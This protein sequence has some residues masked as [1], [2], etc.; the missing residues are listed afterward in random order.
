MNI[1]LLY[2]LWGEL[3]G[4]FSSDKIYSLWRF[5]LCFFSTDYFIRFRFEWIEKLKNISPVD[6][7]T[8]EMFYFIGVFIMIRIIIYGFLE[9]PLRLIFHGKVKKNILSF[10]E[11]M[12][13]TSKWDQSREAIKIVYI[14]APL[15]HKVLFKYGFI[16]SNDLD[17]LILID[18]DSK[19]K[20][21]NDM[22]KM[23]YRWILT[24]IHTLF[25]SIIVW[26]VYSIW[27]FVIIIIVL[28]ISF[29]FAFIFAFLSLNIEY[30]ELIRVKLLKENKKRW[31]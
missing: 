22:M 1:K 13:K 19:E 31:K 25:V 5:I 9:I 18:L 27:F 29:I 11:K 7:R 24:I 17:E 6:L 3:K 28:L 20:E 8:I 26:E 14:I 4:F 23:I 21:F 10:R 30:L 16:S 12:S 2:D 15:F